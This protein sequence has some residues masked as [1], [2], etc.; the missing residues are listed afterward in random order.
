MRYNVWNYIEETSLDYDSE[1][2]IDTGR[3]VLECSDEL[4]ESFETLKEA[5]NYQKIIS[6]RFKE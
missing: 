5:E 2:L 1:D 6:F 3:G 4:C